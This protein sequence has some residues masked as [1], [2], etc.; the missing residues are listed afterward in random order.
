MDPL[1]AELTDVKSLAPIRQA[2][3]A[4]ADLKPPALPVLHAEDL[5]DTNAIQ[6]GTDQT[7][8]SL[9]AVSLFGPWK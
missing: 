9:V 6:T 3:T 2:D 1:L 8:S 5:S 4:P 7:P